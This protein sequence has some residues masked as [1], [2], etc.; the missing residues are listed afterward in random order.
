MRMI[1]EILAALMML[2]VGLLMEIGTFPPYLDSYNFLYILV[3]NQ[4]IGL[5]LHGIRRIREKVE[6]KRKQKKDQKER[7]SLIELKSQTKKSVIIE[8]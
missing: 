1:K 3:V 6:K 7:P 4:I 8:V 2:I 5:I